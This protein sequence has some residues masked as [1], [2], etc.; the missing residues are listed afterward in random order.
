MSAGEGRTTDGL[1]H[2]CDEIGDTEDDEVETGLDP[3]E[4][5]SASRLKV[6]E[7]SCGEVETRMHPR[8]GISILPSSPYNAAEKKQGA[9]TRLEPTSV[10]L[11]GIQ[12]RGLTRSVESGRG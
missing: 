4:L 3:R 9:R 11:R 1:D 5:S 8:A 7:C 12:V 10:S 2:D 6:S